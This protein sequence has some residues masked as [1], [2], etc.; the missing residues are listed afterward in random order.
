M[1]RPLVQEERCLVPR[2]LL[3]CEYPI[4]STPRSLFDDAGLGRSYRCV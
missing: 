1:I 2:A 4:T 3:I